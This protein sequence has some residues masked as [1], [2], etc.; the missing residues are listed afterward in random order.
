MRFFVLLTP[1]A[2]ILAAVLSAAPIPALAQTGF[3]LDFGVF[4]GVPP[5]AD[6]AAAGQPGVWNEAPIGVTALV[7]GGGNEMIRDNFYSNPGNGWSVDL[8]GLE[9]GSYVVYVYAPTNTAVS[10]GAFTLNGEAFASMPGDS[11]GAYIEG[12]SYIS[13]AVEVDAGSIAMSGSDPSFN[14]LAG[15]QVVS[16]PARSRCPVPTRASMASP[17]CRWSCFRSPDWLY[18]CRRASASA[19]RCIDAQL[20]QGP[21]TGSG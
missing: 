9:N 3:N 16:T 5:A 21:P 2:S 6:G 7:A 10:T 18:S 1:C 8:T 14:G 12:V 15:M 13:A 20:H 19:W 4:Y 17:A 11:T